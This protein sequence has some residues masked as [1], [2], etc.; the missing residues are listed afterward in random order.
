MLSLKRFLDSTIGRK[1][2][3]AITGLALLGFLITHLSGNFLIFKSGDAYNGYSHKLITNPLIILAE[4]ILLA[5]FV[6]HFVNGIV[7]TYK[8]KKARPIAYQVKKCAKGASRKSL[9]S[10]LMPITGLILLAFVPLHLLSFKYGAN[11]ASVTDP[12]VRDLY[13]LVMEEFTEVGEVIWYT[14][15][16]A[17][18]GFHLWHGF[19]SA[20]E[21]LGVNH[22]KKIRCVGHV[23]AFLIAAG[24]AAIP[25][26]V[27]WKGGHL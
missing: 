1:V 24:F 15:A 12:Q 14:V 16:M 21:S 13:R 19:M 3:M 27:F 11:Y 7:V 26:V 10:V 22:N 2:I 18:V 23:L 9:S 17:A 8:N 25:L 6:G 4:I 5:L 20:F